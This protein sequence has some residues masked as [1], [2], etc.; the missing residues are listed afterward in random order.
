MEISF[1]DWMAFKD[2][3]SSINKKAFFE[4]SDWVNKKGGY[5]KIPTEDLITYAYGLT[6]KYGEASSTLA[7]LM[8]DAIAELSKASVPPAVPAE[9]AT[10]DEV[11]KSVQGAAKTSYDTEYLAAVIGRL[12][13]QAGADTTLQNA[14]RDGAQFAWIPTG[15]TCMFCITL[16]S[17]GWQYASEKSIKN[18]HAE[19]IHANCDC[20][21]AI[22]FNE[23]TFVENYRPEEYLKLYQSAKGANSKDKINYLRREAYALNKDKINDQKRI[24]YKK[25]IRRIEDA[26]EINVD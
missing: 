1:K 4:F 14:L 19:H 26:D 17:R 22:R 18:G 16:A 5:L 3:L 2:R 10:F 13:K 7:A 8:Y 24:A 6:T 9:T 25:R 20:T 21:Y 12:V 11:A 23:N 15:D